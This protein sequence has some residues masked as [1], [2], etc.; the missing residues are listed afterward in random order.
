[1]LHIF[2]FILCLNSDKKSVFVHSKDTKLSI[3]SHSLVTNVCAHYWFA[4]V[5]ERQYDKQATHIKIN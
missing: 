2:I 4:Y 5:I 3:V 1:M